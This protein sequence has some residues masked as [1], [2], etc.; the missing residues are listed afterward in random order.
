M[1]AS[2]LENQPLVPGAAGDLLAVE[3]FEQRNGVFARHAG[4]R[5]EGGNVDQAVGFV[6]AGVGL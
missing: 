3:V 2:D 5:F 4:Q 1:Q 6:L